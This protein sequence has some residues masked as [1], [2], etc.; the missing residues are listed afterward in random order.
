VS[1]GRLFD[2]LARLQASRSSSARE[3][4]DALGVTDRTIRRDVDRLRA[5]GYQVEATHGSAGGYRLAAGGAMPPLLL[6]DEEAVAIV[7]GMRAAAA[8]AVEGIEDASLRALVK[9]DQ[10]LPA[11][12]R[13]RVGAF[14]V[15][16]VP[17]PDAAQPELL[18][19]LAAAIGRRERIELRYRDREGALTRRLVDP[20]RVIAAHRRWYLLAF[21]TGREDWRTFR[22]DRIERMVETAVMAARRVPPTDPVA[23]VTARLYSLEKTYAAT[24]AIRAS[25]AEARR[26]LG[27]FAERVEG[28]D[29]GCRVTTAS[30]TISWLARRL[31]ALDLDFTIVAPPELIT[32]VR[33][34][35]NRLRRATTE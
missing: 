4:S 23:F 12:L 25:P 26:R 21:D 22:V 35:T 30:D 19:G 6:D 1:S 29:S 5:M 7:V 14:D 16:A 31:A 24:L 15:L 10:V 8:L 18:A 3:L 11:R 28:L 20:H 27:R 33:A 2:L 9:L 34:V 13:R 32:E 17:G